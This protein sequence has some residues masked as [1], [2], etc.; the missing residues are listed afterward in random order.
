M[1]TLTLKCTKYI[2]I[3]KRRKRQE[4]QISCHWANLRP[5]LAAWDHVQKQ[6]KVKQ[7]T[8]PQILTDT[9]CVCVCVCAL[10]TL[11]TTY[12]PS[13]CIYNV[14]LFIHLSV[15]PSAHPSIY[16]LICLPIHRLLV[17][18]LHATFTPSACG[19]QRKASDPLW[20]TKRLK[21]NPV[22][23]KDHFWQDFQG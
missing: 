20:I 14:N 2:K 10:C 23:M 6:S 4:D 9:M 5:A 19:G 11:C 18:C 17:F 3:N 15:Y 7:S 12:M 13:T 21:W 1:K 8:L 22:F 16:P